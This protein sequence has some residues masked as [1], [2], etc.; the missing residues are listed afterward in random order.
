MKIDWMKMADVAIR[1]SSRRGDQ[2]CLLHV[3]ISLALV[4]RQTALAV[5]GWNSTLSV[6]TD[7]DLKLRVADRVKSQNIIHLAKVLVSCPTHSENEDLKRH[8]EEEQMLNDHIKRC[9]LAA[10]VVVVCREDA[11]LT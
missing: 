11:P 1:S 7:Y 8:A 10:Q 3:T 6:A 9:D 4:R 2:I 5:G